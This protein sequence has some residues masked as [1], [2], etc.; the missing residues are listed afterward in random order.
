MESPSISVAQEPLLNWLV[1]RFVERT[2]AGRRS[3]LIAFFANVPRLTSDEKAQLEALIAWLEERAKHE[4]VRP[5][6]ERR[7]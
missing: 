4:D 5:E 1:H 3:P 7:T 6:S 2:L